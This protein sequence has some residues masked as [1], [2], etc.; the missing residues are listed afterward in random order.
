MT[1]APSDIKVFKGWLWVHF[2]W[3]ENGECEF[4][5]VV[6][7]NDWNREALRVKTI[8]YAHTHKM[9]SNIPSPMEKVIAVKIFFFTFITTWIRY[10][11]K[12]CLSASRTQMQHARWIW[13]RLLPAKGKFFLATVANTNGS[14]WSFALGAV[15]FLNV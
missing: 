11:V 13:L 14:V 2:D 8:K 6:A 10:P 4:F 5:L 9:Y 12:C 1:Y 15:S 3:G 7:T